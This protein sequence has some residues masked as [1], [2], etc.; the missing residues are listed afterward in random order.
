MQN[1]NGSLWNGNFISCSPVW[2][3]FLSFEETHNGYEEIFCYTVVSVYEYNVDRQA[4]SQSHNNQRHQENI[5]CI[6]T[7]QQ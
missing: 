6:A 7:E 1:F 3:S 4:G 5:L 2:N